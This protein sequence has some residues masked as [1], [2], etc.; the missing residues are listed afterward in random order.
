MAPSDPPVMP[1]E[2]SMALVLCSWGL[3]FDVDLDSLLAL[4]PPS[5]PVSGLQRKLASVVDEV[6]RQ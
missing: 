5:A 1:G 2:L 4:L 6:L 3:H